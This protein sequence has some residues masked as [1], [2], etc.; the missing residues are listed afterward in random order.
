MKKRWTALLLALTM[1]LALTAC[2]GAAAQEMQTA[3]VFAMDTV[4]GLQATGG[5]TI[6]LGEALV[7]SADGLLTK[8]GAEAKLAS[9]PQHFLKRAERITVLF[10]ILYNAPRRFGRRC[11]VR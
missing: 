9:A 8:C 6:Q 11:F 10:I 1:T 4:M 5:E 7:L 3:Q 2:G